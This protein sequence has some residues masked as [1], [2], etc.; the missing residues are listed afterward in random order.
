MR[1]LVAALLAIAG[2][3]GHASAGCPHDG[4][5]YDVG[6]VIC[7]EGWQQE[8]TPAGYWK[9]IGQCKVPDGRAIDSTR[10]L[11]L[12]EPAVSFDLVEASAIVVPVSGVTWRRTLR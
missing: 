9:A 10:W 7:S 11:P 4:V 8:C 2:G 1:A 6:A 3:A 12:D 5:I